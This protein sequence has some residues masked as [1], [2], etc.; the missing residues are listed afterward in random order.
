MSD[1]LTTAVTLADVKN[2]LGIAVT[3]T[4]EDTLLNLVIPT[5]TA[6]VEAY[7]CRLI[8]SNTYTEY[9]SSN[10]KPFFSLNQRPVTAITNLWLDNGA[11]WG[12]SSNPFASNTLLVQGVDYA[13]F[14]DQP[15]GSSRSGLVENVGQGTWNAPWAYTPGIISPLVAPPIGNIK[16]QYTAGYATIPGNVLLACYMAVARI[17]NMGAYGQAISSERYEEYSVSFAPNKGGIL[18]TE[19][20]S[21]LAPYKEVV[22]G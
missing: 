5:A 10:N 16:V 21:L 1:A 20:R 7:L 11:Y 9:Y 4:T 2:F 13:L 12:Q 22:I 8:G 6:A 3:D 18:T 17:R 14:I 19:I 15:D